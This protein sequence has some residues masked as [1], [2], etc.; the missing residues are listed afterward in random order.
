LLDRYTFQLSPCEVI[1]PLMRL[2]WLG[3]ATASGTLPMGSGPSQGP[4]CE[5]FGADSIESSSGYGPDRAFRRDARKF[6]FRGESGVPETLFAWRA[7][8]RHGVKKQRRRP[9][10]RLMRHRNAHLTVVF[11]NLRISFVGAAAFGN[12]R[13]SCRTRQRM[14]RLEDVREDVTPTSPR[15]ERF[16][17]LS[18]CSNRDGVPAIRAGA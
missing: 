3:H 6:F 15:C 9:H 12:S 13:N 11:C 1:C 16:F 5:S 8:V 10:A 18:A 4:I 14:R 2:R 7:R 17:F